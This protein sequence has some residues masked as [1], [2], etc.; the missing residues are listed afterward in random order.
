MSNTISKKGLW[1]KVHGM[2]NTDERWAVDHEGGV[3]ICPWFWKGLFLMLFTVFVC[4]GLVSS[5]YVIIMVGYTVVSF[6]VVLSGVMSNL[7]VISMGLLFSVMGILGAYIEGYIAF[8][9]E[10]MK[11]PLRKV[12]SKISLPE[13]NKPKA[14][15][16][17]KQYYKAHKEKWC[18]MLTLEES[19][20]D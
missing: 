3:S 9:P 6:L 20:D 11:K 4:V 15:N 17:I 12:F 16:I 2:Y 19:S 13:D 5:V 7:E 18:P 10:Y 14:P 8:A 1:Y